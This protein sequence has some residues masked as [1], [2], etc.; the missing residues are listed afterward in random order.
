MF[1]HIEISTQCNFNCFYCAGRGMAQKRMGLTKFKEVLG[2]IPPGNHTVCLQGEGEPLLHPD[3]WEMVSLVQQAGQTPYTITNGSEIDA[4][5]I[6]ANLP[7]IGVSIDTLDKH[8]ADRIGRKSLPRVLRNLDQLIERLGPSRLVVMTVDYGQPLDELKGFL[9]SKGIFQHIIQP[10]QLKEDYRQA[11]PDIP[12]PAGNY[13][14]QCRFLEQDLQR[15]YDIDGRA[16]P[17]CHIKNTDGYESIEALRESLARREVPAPCIG[18]REILAGVKQAFRAVDGASFVPNISFIVPVKSRLTQLRQTLPTIANQPGCEVIVVDY[19][20]PENSG[21]WAA[22]TFGN[23]MVIKVAAAPILNVARARNI[24]AAKARGRWLCF[25]DV[26]ATMTP[27]FAG[28]VLGRLEDGGFALFS[29]DAPGLVIV[30]RNDFVSV[31]GYDEIFEGWGCEDNDLIT[32]LQLL[33]RHPVLLAG[34]WYSLLGHDDSLRTKHYQ[35]DDRW[36]SWRIN[37]MYLQIKTDLARA[38]RVVALPHGDLKNIYK[39]IRRV[40]LESP[41]GPAEVIVDL[42]SHLDFPQRADWRF[43]R[44]W[45]YRFEPQTIGA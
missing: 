32:R 20:C 7:S 22:S 11:Y 24:G 9:N 4:E 10:L 29:V 43:N 25:L 14:Y 38:M 30:A 33:G 23:V 16:F 40:I 1:I 3:F 18:C 6:A 39:E 2:Q 12:P 42:P 28:R 26:D 31:G 27:D 44:K 37:A 45:V 13:T 34:H 15:T 21:D 41:Y 5:R 35:V 36:V 17:C 8:E 19:D